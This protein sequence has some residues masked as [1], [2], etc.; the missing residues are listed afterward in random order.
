MRASPSRRVRA[1]RAGSSPSRWSSDSTSLFNL[2]LAFVAA[3][4]NDSYRDVQQVIPFIFRLLM[5]VSGVMFPVRQYIEDAEAPAVIRR[6]VALNPM[7]QILDLYR[8][9][10][11]GT[12]VDVVRTAELVVVV[13]LT[14]LFGF[15]YFRVHELAYGRA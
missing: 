6:A 12:P 9:I 10:F 14:L 3:R 13:A 7:V 5:Y 8:W 15:R 1:S 4:L 2:G 11:L